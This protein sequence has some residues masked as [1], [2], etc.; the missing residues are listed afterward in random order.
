MIP[1]AQKNDAYYGSQPL[2]DHINANRLSVV[3]QGSP[4]LI[5]REPSDGSKSP[6][7]ANFGLGLPLR[8]AA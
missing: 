4:E 2:R 1:E 8:S 3:S 6:Q 7:P 5:D